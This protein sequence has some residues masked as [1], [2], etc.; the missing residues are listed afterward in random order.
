MKYLLVA[1]AGALS[2]VA[3]GKGSLRANQPA[4]STAATG[5]N[6][7]MTGGDAGPAHGHGDK[8][9]PCAQTCQGKPTSCDMAQ[10]WIGYEGCG[11]HCDQTLKDQLLSE[12]GCTEATEKDATGVAANNAAID[13]SD[14]TTALLTFGRKKNHWCWFC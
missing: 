4:F 1:C 6:G 11:G 2:T 3:M 8:F 5:M 12:M 14:S 9:P 7:A 13:A 10:E